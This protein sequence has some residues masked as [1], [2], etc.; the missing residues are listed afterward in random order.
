MFSFLSSLYILA[1]SHLLDVKLEKI[2]SYSVLCLTEAFH[3][4][5]A[6]LLFTLVPG[7]LVEVV[8]HVSAFKAF[9]LFLS[10]WVQCYPA[11][12]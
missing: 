12:C 2:F 1:I 3:L 5:E 10:H 8:F 4:A 11:I 6:Y 7:L 9:P